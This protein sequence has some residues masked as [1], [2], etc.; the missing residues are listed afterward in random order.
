MSYKKYPVPDFETEIH[1]GEWMYECINANIRGW[2]HKHY[3][4]GEL[5]G[6]YERYT[7]D[8][9]RKC[10][11]CGAELPEQVFILAELQKMRKI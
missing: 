8:D 4:R 10:P 11:E 7:M 9:E 6:P 3:F 2:I 5:T 1:I